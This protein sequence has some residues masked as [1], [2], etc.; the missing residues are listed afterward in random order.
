ML[1]N[2]VTVY[3][4]NFVMKIK[5]FIHSLN[6]DCMPNKCTDL[7]T[8]DTACRP[9]F[10]FLLDAKKIRLQTNLF[11]CNSKMVYQSKGDWRIV[12]GLESHQGDSLV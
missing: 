3:K 4:M 10:W 11:N 8:K 12:A 2:V 5:I 1:I 6:I 7:G 9:L